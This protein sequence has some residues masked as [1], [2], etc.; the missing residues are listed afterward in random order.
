MSDVCRPSKVISYANVVAKAKLEGGRYRPKVTETTA[1]AHNKDWDECITEEKIIPQRRYVIP[2]CP[3]VAP[4]VGNL[5][6]H[7]AS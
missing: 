7:K 4:Q 5:T 6:S 1:H 2:H 3:T